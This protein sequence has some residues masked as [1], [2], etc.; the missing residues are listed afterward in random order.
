MVTPSIVHV[1][2][3]CHLPV[4]LTAALRLHTQSERVQSEQQQKW[5]RCA[6]I[7]V[8]SLPYRRTVARQVV[9]TEVVMAVYRGVFTTCVSRNGAKP[10]VLLSL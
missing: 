7:R 6:A 2:R 9:K 1:P 10:P 5:T 8:G 3:P 4:T